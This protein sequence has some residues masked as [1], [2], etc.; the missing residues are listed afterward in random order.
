MSETV[1]NELSI[2]DYVALL[3]RRKWIIVIAVVLAPVIAYLLSARQPAV[4]DATATVAIKEGNIAAT[5]SGIQDNSFYADPHR[6]ALTQITLARTPAV[7][8]AVLK[9]AKI[10]NGD[11]YALLGST[12]IT[13][14]PNSDI[15]DFT[16]QDH[17]RERA[18]LLAN[19]YAKQY[20]IF[21]SFLDTQSYRQA[22]NSIITRAAEL[23]AE[24]RHAAANALNEK[25]VQ[26]QTFTELET[27]NAVVA[28]LAKGAAQ[29]APRPR[30]NAGFGLG[31]GLLLG[32]GLAFLADALDTRLRG[33][34]DVARRTGLPLLARIPP[35][36]RRLQ[37]DEE[38]VLFKQP[39]SP[40]A[41]AF[42]VLRTNIEFTSIELTT[43][44]I[45]I[46][47]SLEKEG[48]ST[49]ISNL[50]IVEARAGKRVVLLDLDLRR[51]RIDKFFKLSGQPGLTNVILGHASLDEA[52]AHIGLGAD[53]DLSQQGRS[54]G[55]SNGRAPIEGVLDVIPS[56]PIPPDPGE[57]VSTA[58]LTR[59]LD[60]LGERYDL[61]LIDS[62]P[63]LRVGD[64]LTLATKVDALIVVTQVQS[65]RRP[66]LNELKRVLDNCPTRALGFI[67]TGAKAGDGYGQGYY[68]D[69]KQRG[70][71]KSSEA[72][73]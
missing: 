62:P 45:M 66:I 49:T 30:R 65:L 64:G 34:D 31:L 38:L 22:R 54:N 42:R 20:T 1:R 9:R 71:R 70:S 44:R 24:G 61:V 23:D 36:P 33:P 18:A 35:P 58:A 72:T 10:R 12:S 4:Y 6:L 60:E 16:V 53:G 8:S 50:A 55:S 46:T 2:R 15:L 27:S 39:A 13:A 51:P 29:I 32:I 67:V 40:E 73:V 28:N 69:Y 25:A 19:A 56:G 52:T 48:K 3:R 21:R 14:D 5:V 68:Y 26:L 7:A 47:S 59:L 11:P 63:I 57:F 41:E 17:D 43:R 37:R